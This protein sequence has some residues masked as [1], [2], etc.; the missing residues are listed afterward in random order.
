MKT[1]MGAAPSARALV[2]LLAVAM[3][4]GISGTARADGESQVCGPQTLQGSYVF[5]ARGF[6]IVSGVAQPKAIVEGI[7]FNGDGT[8]SVPFATLSVNGVI[9][10]TPPGGVGTYT[11][12]TNCQGTL[13]FTNGPT[14]NIYVPP[15]GRQVS[16]IQTTAN[17]VFQGTASKASR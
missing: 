15:N 6:N 8:L 5:T 14:Y 7:D 1:I 12:E 17:T 13:T 11:V 16:M 4:F 10:V 3:P 9:I 2:S